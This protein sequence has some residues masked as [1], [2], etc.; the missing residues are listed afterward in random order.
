MNAD[1]RV[2]PFAIGRGREVGYRVLLAPDA[3]IDNGLLGR[4]E[5]SIDGAEGAR[6][7]DVDLGATGY[8]QAALTA[9]RLRAD[10]GGFAAEAEDGEWMLD[11]HGRPLEVL[12]GFL[13][14]GGRIDAVEQ[15][16]LE[17]TKATVAQLLPDFLA[18]EAGWQVAR[19]QPFPPQSIVR[20]DS[21]RSRH[22]PDPGLTGEPSIGRMVAMALGALV[23]LLGLV[24]LRE[25]GDGGEPLQLRPSTCTIDSEVGQ[26]STVISTGSEDPVP[27]TVSQRSD[28]PQLAWEI[29]EDCSSVVVDRPCVLTVSVV[30][31]D[32]TTPAEA[33]LRIAAE[34]GD[35]V[36]LEVSI[37]GGRD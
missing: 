10:D 21:V 3:I 29:A 33:Q 24:A 8:T 18:D 1:V 9:W 13:V 14:S 34:D 16:D 32:T 12:H 22:R 28:G 23:V 2:W 27:F 20:M 4:L 31:Q 26:C 30:A 37:G 17:S 19:S 5:Q 35:A 6:T 36:Q 25:L 15:A 7:I 11:R